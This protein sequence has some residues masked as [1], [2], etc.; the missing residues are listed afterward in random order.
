MRDKKAAAYRLEDLAADAM[1]LLDHLG[2]ERAHL[3]GVSMGGMIAQTIAARRPERVLSLTS[4]MSSTGTRW[5]GQPALK[6]YRQ[7][8]R[9]VSTDR[10]TY[11]AQT[12]ALFEIIGSPG[13]DRA[14]DDLRDLLGRM[15]DRGH[16]AGSVTRQ[17]AAIL[18]SG[19]RTAELRHIT[20]PTLVIHGTADKLVAP[21]GGR[22]TARAIPGAR[23]LMI[24]GMGHDLPR[25]AWPQLID[26][27]VENTGRAPAGL[28]PAPAVG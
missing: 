11:I 20:A 25:G 23:L 6:T 24:D 22:A 17:L 26:A 19:D 3:V 9:P 28:T 1:G 8:L 16:D 13:F 4:I 27:I 5:R 21:S 10:A 15:Y 7:F 12:A 2:I 18:A 14:D